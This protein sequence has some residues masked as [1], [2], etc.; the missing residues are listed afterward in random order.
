MFK[1]SDTDEGYYLVVS[2][3]VP[4]KRIDLVA[5]AFTKL[6]LPLKI[7]GDGS[8]YKNVASKA[9]RQLNAWTR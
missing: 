8:E 1:K 5:E 4:Y 2:R 7:I 3:L 9:G 6:G